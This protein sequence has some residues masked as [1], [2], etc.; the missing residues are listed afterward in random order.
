MAGSAIQ[1]GGF[2]DEIV[3]DDGVEGGGGGGFE[4]EEAGVV[5]EFEWGDGFDGA[6]GDESGD[7]ESDVGE[8]DD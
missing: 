7:D 5:H 3:G 1:P 6:V 8:S 2:V 4:G